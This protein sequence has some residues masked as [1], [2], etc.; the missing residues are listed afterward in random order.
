[1]SELVVINYVTLGGRGE[2]HTCFT[3]S[4]HPSSCA[5]LHLMKVTSLAPNLRHRS[6]SSAGGGVLLYVRTS[7]DP[8]TAKDSAS[9]WPIAPEDPGVDRGLESR[10]MGGCC[11]VWEVDVIAYQ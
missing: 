11:V 2:V 1:M 8:A 4:W 10:V 9:P 3:R 6:L 7:L 5:T